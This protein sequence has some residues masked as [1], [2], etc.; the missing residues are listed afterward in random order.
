MNSVSVSKNT[1]G[2]RCRFGEIGNAF[3]E[4]DMPLLDAALHYLFS[5]IASVGMTGT[6][7]VGCAELVSA[8]FC[9]HSCL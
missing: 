4:V 6:N 7:L 9:S 1:L 2:G 5:S 3:I 8:V